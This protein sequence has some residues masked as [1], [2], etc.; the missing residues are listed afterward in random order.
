M[1]FQTIKRS[2]TALY[3]L[4]TYLNASAVLTSAT[5]RGTKDQI[6]R[7]KE[8]FLNLIREKHLDKVLV[9]SS[10]AW[11]RVP[12]TRE[13]EA[14]GKGALGLDPKKFSGFSW[15]TYDAN[16]HIVMAFGLRHPQGAD[17]VRMRQ[18][19]RHILDMP[20]EKKAAD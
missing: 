3:F 8:R 10:V 5:E 2:G 4:T 18:A 11:S 12:A 15:G 7:A 14:T 16:G 9:F 20:L 19:V 13:E 1:I 17:R 6:K